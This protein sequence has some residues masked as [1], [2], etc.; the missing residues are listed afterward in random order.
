MKNQEKTDNDLNILMNALKEKEE[1]VLRKVEIYDLN[2]GDWRYMVSLMKNLADL[3]L[4]EIKGSS[5][6]IK[7]QG[8][9][10]ITIQEYRDNSKK[11]DVKLDLELIKIKNELKD[12]SLF[13]WI[14]IIGAI[15]GVLGLI[16]SLIK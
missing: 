3:N 1:G 15:S 16:I 14:S 4:A 5:L 7:A 8:I 10:F 9:D 13:K 6:R 2:L 12:Y 11:E